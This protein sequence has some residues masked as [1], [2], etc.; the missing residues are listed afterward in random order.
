M[1]LKG[2][3]R[4]E[5]LWL[6]VFST[7]ILVLA[8]SWKSSILGVTVYLTGVL[9]VVLAAKGNLWNYAFGL[10]NSIGYAWLSYQ[11]GLYG[12]VM[13]NLLFFVPTGVIG[14][15]M[16]RKRSRDNKVLMRKMK[17]N[18]IA[19]L[20]LLCMAATLAYGIWLSTLKG[21]NTPFLDAFSVVASILAT[22]AMMLR[23]REQWILYISV[24]IVETVMWMIRLMNGS[25]DAPTMV[26]MWT[27]YLVNSVYGLYVW[28][29]GARGDQDEKDGLGSGEVRATP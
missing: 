25:S 4:F 29:K 15:F 28:N 2:W 22:L 5:V 6:A 24:N 26:V 11:N 7:I 18:G 9:C 12:E 3:N 14:W 1:K 21:Q 8:F 10:Y 17:G 27:A 23:Y 19:G 20:V 16:W 13:L